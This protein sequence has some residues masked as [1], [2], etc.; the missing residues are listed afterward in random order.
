MRHDSSPVLLVS[1]RFAIGFVMRV[2]GRARPRANVRRAS[3]ARAQF[4]RPASDPA[5][6]RLRCALAYARS[7][8][9]TDSGFF[10]AR[11]R[12]SSKPALANSAASSARVRA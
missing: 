12:A 10:A 6:L 1:A 4:T 7:A 5:K 9:S 3:R 8:S 11:T 2:A